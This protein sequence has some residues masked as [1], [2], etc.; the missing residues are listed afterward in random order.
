MALLIVSG[1]AHAANYP[2]EIIQPQSNLDTKSRFYKAYPGIP[3]EMRM[4]VI[5][6]DYPFRYE[7]ITAPSGMTINANTGVITWPN[8]TT[9][10]SPATVTAR[11]TDLGGSGGGIG[12][13]GTQRSVTWTITVTTSGFIFVDA[14]KGHSRWGSPAGDGSISN[15]FLT[16]KDFLCVTQACPEA[17]KN[18]TTHQNYFVYFRA[19]TYMVDGPLQPSSPWGTVTLNKKPVVWMEYPGEN[20]ILDFALGHPLVSSDRNDNYFSG[21]EMINQSKE[22]HGI[23]IAVY[24][25][26]ARGRNTFWK[27]VG[28]GMSGTK[29]GTVSSHLYIPYGRCCGKYFVFQDNEFYNDH[30]GHNIV[31]YEIM[32]AL[33]EGNHIHDSDHINGIAIKGSCQYCVIRGNRMKNLGSATAHAV[34]IWI[35]DQTTGPLTGEIEILYNNILAG[36]ANGN[37][38][39]VASFNEAA[40]PASGVHYIYRNTFVGRIVFTSIDLINGPYYFNNNV[41]ISDVDLTQPDRI[42]C[43]GGEQPGGGTACG[44]QIV[45]KNNLVGSSSGSLLDVNGNL[46]SGYASSLGTRGYQLSSPTSAPKA[47][48]NLR[49]Q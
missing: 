40:T 13:G 36:T 15:P 2:L 33:F 6:G 29:I 31:T 28:H 18:A 11:V 23:A 22:G 5:G 45:P 35:Y 27:L 17:D 7:L 39:V 4:G 25:Q 20:A 30:S 21:F 32:Y 38:N 42:G 19:G 1:Q 24:S 48:A 26:N 10:G 49:A 41:I 12:L 14:V 34:G 8:P 16:M 37:N 47:G 9:A 3:Y 43:V 44:T 46:T